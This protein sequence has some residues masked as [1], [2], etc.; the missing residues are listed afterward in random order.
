M[1]KIRIL[2]TSCLGKT[3]FLLATQLNKSKYY[4]FQVFGCDI[5]KTKHT[6]KYFKKIFKVPRGSEKNYIKKLINY[7]IRNKIKFIL[8]GSDEEAISLSK[9]KE[10]LD[11]YKIVP[12]ISGEKELNLISNKYNTYKYLKSKKIYVPD[13]YLISNKNELDVV[14]R[15]LGYP[16]KNIVIKPCHGR[17]GRNVIYL[18]GKGDIPLWLMKGQRTKIFKR[19]NDVK[20]IFKKKNE[21]IVM[22]LLNAPCYDVDILEIFGQKKKY[23][24][25]LRKRLNPNG[26]PYEGYEIIKNKKLESYVCSIYKKLNL[27]SLHDFDIMTDEN[28]S[29]VLLEVNPRPSGSL[30]ASHMAGVPIIDLAISRKLDLRINYK[31]I[32]N[33]SLYINF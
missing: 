5:N 3:G 12:L 24:C 25:V 19:I 33:K 6:D 10:L 27:K 22:S 30:V 4:N 13:H 1:K 18:K 28:G 29:P 9:S 8:P 20:K 23:E 2:I 32:N 15:S 7:L 17:G 16:N 31:K 26:L 11:K 21:F 14:L